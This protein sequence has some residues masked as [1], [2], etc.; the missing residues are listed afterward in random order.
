[1]RSWDRT[2]L[3][4]TL[5]ENPGHLYQVVFP[6]LILARLKDLAVRATAQGIGPSFAADLRVIVDSLTKAP[7]SWGDPSHRLHQLGLLVCNRVFARLLVSYAID[8]QRRI[9][10][11]RECRPLDNHP[12]ERAP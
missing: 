4:L 11:V 9:V 7:M 6:Q 1:M 2:D 8:E 3:R 10:Y 5:T 12:L